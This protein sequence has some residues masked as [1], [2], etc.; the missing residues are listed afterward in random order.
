MTPENPAVRSP[1]SVARRLLLCLLPVLA[2]SLL[3]GTLFQLDFPL[4]RFVRTLRISWLEKLGDLGN[5]LG[6]GL[7]LVLVS[8]AL[9]VGGWLWGHA[10][11]RQAGFQSLIAHG[12]AGLFTQILKRTLGR[13]RPRWTHADGWHLEEVGPSLVSGLDAFPSGHAAASCA[14]AVILARHYPRAAWLWYL[15]AGWVVASRIIKGS[16]FPS[17]V[18]GGMLVGFL[19]GDLVVGPWWDWRR[20]A[21]SAG[22]RLLPWACAFTGLLW[23]VVHDRGHGAF[24]MASIWVGLAVMIAGEGIRVAGLVTGGTNEHLLQAGAVVALG[25]VA[26]TTGSVLVTAVMLVAMGTGWLKGNLAMTNGSWRQEGLLV[27]GLLA[28]VGVLHQLQGLV[29]LMN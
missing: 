20:A 29:P 3:F 9:L 6:D 15:V 16:H 22:L 21:G 2:Y 28:A 19:A 23:I 12:L 8:C 4:I 1:W 7:T 26:L 14:V 18:L 25:G 11:T 13:P 24:A 17:D 5:Q 10:P 27:G